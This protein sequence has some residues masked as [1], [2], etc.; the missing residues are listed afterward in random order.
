MLLRRREEPIQLKTPA[1]IAV[2]REA[3]LVVA[4]ALGAVTGAIE[5]GISTA[6]LDAIAER[7]IRSAG[8][9]P[10]FKGYHGYPACICTSV[11]EQVVHG[12]PSTRQ[13]LKPGDLIS[14]DCG[15]I[16]HGYHGDAA[17]TV[18]VGELGQPLADLAGAC[19]LAL[20]AGIAQARPGGHLTDISHAIEQSVLASGAY[21]IIREYTGHG[22]GTSMHMPP[23]VPNYGR[24]G[25]GPLLAEGMT[26]AIEPML[27]LGS[28][29][30][31]LLADGW[32]VISA[33]GSSAAHFEH[34]VAI[35]ADGPVVLTA[36]AAGQAGLEARDGS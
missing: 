30:T 25:R 26:L 17:V 27:V 19:E 32:T 23:A 34:T 22:I 20:R 24:P 28:P 10:S 36:A 5:P 13:L 31:R 18:G 7:A 1:Q 3:G 14:V 16:V 33:D 8:A 15:A 35:T 9:T 11:N 21:G 2:M 4:T 12:I 29:V 6:E